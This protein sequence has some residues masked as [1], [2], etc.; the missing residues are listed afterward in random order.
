MTATFSHATT[1]VL[2]EDIIPMASSPTLWMIM[3]ALIL[4]LILRYVWFP[5]LSLQTLDATIKDVGK[6][7]EGY[8]QNIR[9]QCLSDAI[10]YDQ[11]KRS[12]K[13]FEGQLLRIKRVAHKRSDEDYKAAT[14]RKYFSFSRAAMLSSSYKKLLRLKTDIE[15]SNVLI[16]N[17]QNDQLLQMMR[18]HHRNVSSAPEENR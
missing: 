13:N 4:S 12:F 15:H 6:L 9:S 1:Q 17:D 16:L 11:H 18:L 7:L 2:T 10:D 5:C 3:S 8:E 14:W